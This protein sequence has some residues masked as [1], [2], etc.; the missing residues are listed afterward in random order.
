MPLLRPLTHFVLRSPATAGARAAGPGPLGCRSLRRSVSP[1]PPLNPG[2]DSRIRVTL[3]TGR[4]SCTT[5]WAHTG[6]QGHPL[7]PS[8]RGCSVGWPGGAVEP[9][10]GGAIISRVPSTI[11]P[12][13]ISRPYEEESPDVVPRPSSRVPLFNI[14]VTPLDRESLLK[15]LSVA[16]ETATSLTIVGHNLHSVY[17]FHTQPAFR[18]L[19]ENAEVRLIDGI[20]VLAVLNLFRLASGRRLYGS[21]H[22][23]GSTDWILQA[24][25]APQIKRVAVL[26]AQAHSNHGAIQVLKAA[27]PSTE[28]VGLP[29]DPWRP[30][31]LERVVVTIKDFAPDLLLIGMGMP[32]QEKI[33]EQLRKEARCPLIIACVGAAIDQ[34]SGSQSLAPRWLGRIGLEWVWRLMSDPKRFSSRYLVEPWRLAMVLARRWR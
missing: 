18:E 34:F 6:Q 4:G 14:D 21:K 28:Y 31:D 30:G 26:G 13:P 22:R 9:C 11:A 17:L 33:A 10:F 1:M 20:S 19:Y 2:R 24:A 12:T 29:A 32:L 16:L 7:G 15:E 5:L 3:T 23:L 27:A 8:T 25:R